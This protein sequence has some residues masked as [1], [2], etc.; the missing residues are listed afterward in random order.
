MSVL[1]HIY[2][3][4]YAAWRLLVGDQ[5]AVEL[6]EPTLEAFLK[7][8]LAAFLA[9][10]LFAALVYLVGPA[11][12]VDAY[13]FFFA[14]NWLLTP[15]IMY[16]LLVLL[17]LQ[18]GFYRLMIARNWARVIVLTIF[19]L[20]FLVLRV[21]PDNEALSAGLGL[22]MYAATLYYIWSVV[23]TALGSSGGIAVAVVAVDAFLTMALRYAI[24]P[25]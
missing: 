2:Q 14:A 7:S 4:V 24:L 19:L 15:L 17:K 1:A 23:R 5:S 16:V 18:A 20:G 9:A 11:F 13:A 10:P 3:S 22:I 21:L 12:S 6:F 8:F 25:V